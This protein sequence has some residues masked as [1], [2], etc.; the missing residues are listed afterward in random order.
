MAPEPAVPAWQ[1]LRSVASGIATAGSGGDVPAASNTFAYDIN[2]SDEIAGYYD[3]T[4][5]TPHGFVQDQHGQLTTVDV[6][7]AVATFIL[8][9]DDRGDLA[10]HFVDS[11]G[12]I[13]GFVAFKK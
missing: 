4:T 3:D 2:D 13:L 9:N 7:G 12:A 5:A 8:G 10:G 6:P 11:I 1:R